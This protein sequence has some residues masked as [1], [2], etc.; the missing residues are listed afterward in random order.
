MTQAC[1]DWWLLKC[2]WLGPPILVAIIVI[3]IIGRLL[4]R[5]R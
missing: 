4:N 2:A 5:R 3:P 1:V